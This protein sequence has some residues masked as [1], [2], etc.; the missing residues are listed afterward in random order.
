M[1]PEGFIKK[2]LASINK[3]L[4]PLKQNFLEVEQLTGLRKA[5]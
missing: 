3:F 4:V 1:G 5:N 2:N